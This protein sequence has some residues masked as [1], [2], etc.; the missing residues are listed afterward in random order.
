MGPQPQCLQ[1][2][3]SGLRRDRAYFQLEAYMRNILNHPNRG[4]PSSTNI[5][6]PAFG[7]FRLGGARNIQIRLRIGL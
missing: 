1:A 2:L 6:S 7:Q 3:A 5:T 4:G